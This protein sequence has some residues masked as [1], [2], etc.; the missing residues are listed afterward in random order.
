VSEEPEGGS[1]ADPAESIPKAVVVGEGDPPVR[2]SHLTIDPEPTRFP[3]DSKLSGTVRKIDHAVG[4]AEQWFV[5]GLLA[6]VVVVASLAAIHDKLTTEHLGRWWHTIVRGGTFAIALF[7]AAFATHEQRHL[8]MDLVSRKLSVKGRLIL[9]LA[10]KVLTVGV[11]WYLY[12]GGLAQLEYCVTQ[13]V[14]PGDVHALQ[15]QSCSAL[16]GKGE[17]LSLFGM[18]LNDVDVVSSI[19][20]A[21]L[22][23]AFHT[24]LHFIIDVDYLVRGVAPPERMRAH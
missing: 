21:A 20:I 13:W 19:F 11:C 7:A 24:V 17:T 23:I 4:L 12:K 1:S 22:L 10:L 14:G 8:A 15:I 6:L 5:F 3:N 16:V 18:H 9:G 2:D